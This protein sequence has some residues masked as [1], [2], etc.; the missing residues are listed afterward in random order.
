MRSFAWLFLPCPPMTLP[1][2]LMTRTPLNSAPIE[3]LEG[4]VSSGLILLCD[5][6]CATLPPDLDLGL[7]QDVLSR[8]VAYDIGAACVTR[9]MAQNLGAPA[10]LTNFSRLVIDPNRGFD[11]PTLI[12]Q[13]S[14]GT[15][16]PG[17]AKLTP[18]ERG[19]R[20]Q[21]FCAPYDKAIT[22]HI[23]ASLAAGVTPSLIAIHSFTP[24]WKGMMRPWHI[25]IL[26]EEDDRLAA[27]LLSALRKDP[28]LCIGANEPYRAGLPGDTLQRHGSMRGLPH[29]L[30]EFRQD[31]IAQEAGALLW[32]DKLAALLQIFS[33]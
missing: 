11:D 18:Q 13:I 29:V 5:H 22:G 17:N 4:T 21:R 30:L 31:L 2:P 6:A 8:H 9:R 23:D 32:A 15:I 16:V 12:M 25:G 28:D 19:A 7:G 26:W 1:Y 27:P 14:D 33:V 3:I 10:I 20:W 24:C